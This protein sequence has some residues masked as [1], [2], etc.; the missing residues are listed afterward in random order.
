MLGSGRV[1]QKRRTRAA[2]IA[3][4]KELL[5]QGAPPTV[6][7]AAELAEVSRTTA[8]R[9]F[10]TQES[11]LVEIAIGVG[12]DDVDELAAR[13]LGD[14]TAEQRLLAVLHLLNERLLENE[15]QY[16]TALRLYLDLWLEEA[17]DGGEPAVLREGR[18]RRWITQSLASLETPLS[19]ADSRRLT[20]ALSLVAGIEAL[21]TL[22]DVCGLDAEEA[23]AVTDWA[24]EALLRSALDERGAKQARRRTG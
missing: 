2:I 15:A 24:A 22:R 21:V 6:A 11:L 1:N 12:V 19:P 8:Y 17:K 10:P 13:P 5:A 18:R 7:Q 20:A 3:A 4:A 23:L 9:Y 16:R 14:E